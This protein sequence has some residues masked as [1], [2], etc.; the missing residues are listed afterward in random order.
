M[1]GKMIF[2]DRSNMPWLHTQI[3]SKKQVKVIV[4][5]RGV[6]P[7]KTNF[8]P[9]TLTARDQTPKMKLIAKPSYLN[10]EKREQN[11]F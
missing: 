7:K 1:Q 3:H 11:I 2:S 10:P 9:S 6:K 8:I 5:Y 4:F